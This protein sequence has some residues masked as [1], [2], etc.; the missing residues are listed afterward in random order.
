MCEEIADDED[1]PVNQSDRGDLENVIHTNISEEKG[2]V[3]KFWKM[4]V[5]CRPHARWKRS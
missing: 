4:F 1:E 2:M 5:G 3:N